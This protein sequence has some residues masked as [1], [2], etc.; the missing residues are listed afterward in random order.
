MR[1]RRIIHP[2]LTLIFETAQRAMPIKTYRLWPS[3]PSEGKELNLEV[4]ETWMVGR[5][6]VR[7]EG[8]WTSP[9]GV[10]SGGRR[11]Y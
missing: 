3:L 6:V 2:E 10:M 5:R 11:R 4:Y 1:R 7:V 9:T 8:G